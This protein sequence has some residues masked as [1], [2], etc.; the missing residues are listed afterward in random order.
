MSDGP[1]TRYARAAGG[2][3]P[4]DWW[5]LEARALSGVPELRR[6]LAFFAPADAWRDLAKDTAAG[7]GCLL[8]LSHIASFTLPAVAAVGTLGWIFGRSGDVPL[9]LLGIL[10][11]IAAV[12]GAIGLRTDRREPG[13]TDPKVGRLLGVLHLV[14]ALVGLLV[15]LS[16]LAQGAATGA[17]GLV[18]F[19][20]DAVV[21]ALHFVVHRGAA[22]TGTERWRRNLQRLEAA[23]DAL[24]PA[25]RARVY[26][27]LQQAFDVL[28]TRGIVPGDVLTRARDVRIGLL[29]MTLAPRD[30][31]DPRAPRSG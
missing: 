3:A 9:G 25:E 21:G 7:W 29:G 14:P 24:P 23:S 2:W 22:D 4:L 11:A 12:I 16:A 10:A 8:T 18:G 6:A 31:L 13:G 1:A 19:V 26:S 17:I 30:D 20:L 5:K 28:E 15:G 27:D